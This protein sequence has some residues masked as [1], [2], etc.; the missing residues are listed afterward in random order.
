MAQSSRTTGIKR[1]RPGPEET[2]SSTTRRLRNLSSVEIPTDDSARVVELTS[3][4][5]RNLRRE[6]H[7][8]RW[9]P[10]DE[11]SILVGPDHVCPACGAWAPST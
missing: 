5:I 1:S 7:T 2:L 3:R 6:E 8:P 10:A 9:C 4:R 11:V